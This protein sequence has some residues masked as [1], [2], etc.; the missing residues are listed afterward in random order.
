M[1]E[2]ASEYTKN[3][4]RKRERERELKL[5][6]ESPWT[7][8]EA[9]VA[10]QSAWALFYRMRAA[11]L[12]LRSSRARPAFL[13]VSRGRTDEVEA[14]AGVVEARVSSQDYVYETAAGSLPEYGSGSESD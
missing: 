11:E 12:L 4:F 9:Q 2:S 1:C 3:F 13:M 8:G 5:C 7:V 14:T 6:N 10:K